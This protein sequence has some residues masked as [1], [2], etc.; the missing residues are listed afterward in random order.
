MRSALVLSAP[1]SLCSYYKCSSPGVV[2]Q[3]HVE[4]SMEQP[5]MFVVRE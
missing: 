4:R 1:V 5:D 2:M 3:K